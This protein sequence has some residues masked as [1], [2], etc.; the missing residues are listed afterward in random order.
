VIERLTVG[1][2]LVNLNRCQTLTRER[3]PKNHAFRDPITGE[4]FIHNGLESPAFSTGNL[5]GA[6]KN[7]TR[8]GIEQITLVKLYRGGGDVVSRNY[9]KGR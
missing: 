9:T 1:T 6:G 5:W 4:K 2:T 3:G 8:G 7:F